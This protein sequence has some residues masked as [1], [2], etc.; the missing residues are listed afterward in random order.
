MPAPDIILPLNNGLKAWVWAEAIENTR[1]GTKPIPGGDKWRISIPTRASLADAKGNLILDDV[2]NE[3]PVTTPI[4]TKTF[5]VADLLHHPRVA[6]LVAETDAVTKLILLGEIAPLSTPE[7]P[8]NTPAVIQVEGA[9]DDHSPIL[10]PNA[11][12]SNA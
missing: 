1:Q 8:P 7:V 12:P 6:A 4:A 5:D 2:G 11:E 3:I 10:T 9:T